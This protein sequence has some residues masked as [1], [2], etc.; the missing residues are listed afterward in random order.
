MTI[1]SPLAP[2]AS[3]PGVEDTKASRLPSGDQATSLPVP[4]SGLL[5]PFV[6]ARKVTSD[7]SARAT[8]SPD[9]SPWLPERANHFPRGDQRGP[10]EAS[11]RP[12]RGADFC[13]PRSMI[14]NWP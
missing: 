12:P 10:P 4:G 1:G 8:K 3:V 5:V 9:L 7:P 6:G 11:C 2:L 14:H 13:D